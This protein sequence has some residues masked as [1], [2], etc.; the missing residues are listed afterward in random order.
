MVWSNGR[1]LPNLEQYLSAFGDVQFILDHMGTSNPRAEA[2]GSERF[3]DFDAV[4][5]LGR[6]FGNLAVKW[7]T[8]ESASAEVYP[9]R[10]VFP[11]LLSALDV[12]GRERILWA[13]DWSEHKIQQSWAQSFWWILDSDELSD[14]DKEWILGRSTRTLL[15]WPAVGEDVSVGMYLNCSHS[16]PAIRISG[17]SEDEFVENMRAHLDRW[18]PHQMTRE[19]ML[20]RARR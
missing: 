4:F 10:D 14:A 12:F 18:H 3:G 19:Q 9:Y 11:Y 15:R 2:T 8:V 20:A 6:R 5:E 13:S 17:R 16:H 7:S 1:L